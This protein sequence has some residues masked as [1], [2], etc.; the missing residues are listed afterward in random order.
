M[1][2]IMGVDQR[3]DGPAGTWKGYQPL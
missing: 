2:S 3:K 1:D